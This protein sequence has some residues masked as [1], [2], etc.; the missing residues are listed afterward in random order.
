MTI[1]YHTS[2]EGVPSFLRVENVVAA[3]L[4][5]TS[6]KAGH[7]KPFID[8]YTTAGTLPSRDEADIRWYFGNDQDAA[9]A[10]GYLCMASERAGRPQPSHNQI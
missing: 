7:P 10:W 2:P 9:A 1:V 3:Y 8:I 5:M 4:F 6:L